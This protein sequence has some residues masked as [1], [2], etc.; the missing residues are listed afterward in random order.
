M[1]LIYFALALSRLTS[2]TITAVG[3]KMKKKNVHIISLK[4]LGAKSVRAL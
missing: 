1:I 3:G 2:Q 4:A